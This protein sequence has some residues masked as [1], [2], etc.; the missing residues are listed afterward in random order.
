ML[1]K[2]DTSH[3]LP[4]FIMGQ[5]S[6]FDPGSGVPSESSFSA[7]SEGAEKAHIN[8]ESGFCFRSGSGFVVQSDCFPNLSKYN[9]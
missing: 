2:T 5:F 1:K 6:D 8:H 3:I 4:R 7:T 9:C